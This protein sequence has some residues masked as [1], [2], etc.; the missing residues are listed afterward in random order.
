MIRVVARGTS[1]TAD[2]YLTPVLRQYIDGFFNGFDASLR[3]TSLK[4]EMSEE[5][6]KRTTSVE[7]MRSDGGLTDV[8]GFSG[9]KVCSRSRSQNC[10]DAYPQVDPERTC[11]RS[12]GLCADELGE[13]RTG[14][15]WA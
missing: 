12:R 9:L 5:E 15:D 1:T 11:G 8:A 10:A 2:A 14:G 4:G 7:F 6:A 13:G 3:E